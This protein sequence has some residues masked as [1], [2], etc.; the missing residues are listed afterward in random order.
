MDKILGELLL[1]QL[2]LIDNETNKKMYEVLLK[3]FSLILD[4]FNKVCDQFLT[5]I[6]TVIKKVISKRTLL[7]R[8]SY[9]Q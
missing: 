3:Q 7:K 5:E 1:Q 4:N 8:L 9:K 6:V 2:F